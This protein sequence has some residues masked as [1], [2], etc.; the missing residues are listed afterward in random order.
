MKREII[1]FAG[2]AFGAC[3]FSQQKDEVLMK[4]NN[5]NI[6]RSEFEYIYNKNNS[7]NELDKKSL[8]EYVNL[9]VNFKLKVAAA[10]SE[11]VDTTKAFRDEFLDIVNNWQSPISRTTL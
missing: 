7:N 4:I 6:T 11:G 8:E 1:L 2:L 10:E 5:K 9:F 3:T